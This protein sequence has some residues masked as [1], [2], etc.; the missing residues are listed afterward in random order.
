M[1]RSSA[2]ATEGKYQ[3]KCCATLEL[4]VCC[5]LVV[6]PK[7]KPCI[8]LA[9]L[10]K[11]SGGRT[12]VC[13]R[14]SSAAVLGECPPSLRHAP[15]SLRPCSNQHRFIVLCSTIIREQSRCRRRIAWKCKGA[16]KVA[17]LVV[18]FDVELDF[19]AGEGSYSV[20][21]LV[22]LRTILSSYD[23]LSDD[24][25]LDLHIGFLFRGAT[26]GEG[27]PVVI[28]AALLT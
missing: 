28:C 6:G 16:G 14:K 10:H 21:L 9:A 3:V 23:K 2:T 15:L 27:G 7:S 26:P 25:I 1:K 19:L 22:S 24:Y 8:S 13:L 18:R 4:V 11:I 20:G 17:Y 5:G 12:S